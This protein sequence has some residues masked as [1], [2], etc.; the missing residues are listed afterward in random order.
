MDLVLILYFGSVLA[1]G[2][3]GALRRKQTGPV[4]QGVYALGAALA[5]GAAWLGWDFSPSFTML[6]LAVGLSRYAAGA[7]LWPG[8]D[9]IHVCE[10]PLKAL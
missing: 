8:A 5:I 4:I 10:R 7:R 1:M 9:S 3:F 6:F 2:A